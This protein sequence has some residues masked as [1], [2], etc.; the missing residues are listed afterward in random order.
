MKEG[1][2]QNESR[3]RTLDSNPKASRQA[4]IDVILQR[5]KE[6]NIQREED[7]EL[8]QGRFDTAQREELDEEELLQGKFDFI[9]TT[10]QEPVQREK[11]S[12]IAR[13]TVIQRVIIDDIEVNNSTNMPSW[14]QDGTDYHINLT[15]E[16]PHV[17]ASKARMPKIHFFFTG[18]GFEIEDKQP[19]KEE[20]GRV[21][22]VKGESIRTST[23]FSKLPPLV[24]TF[25]KK[26]WVAIFDGK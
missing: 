7:E 15:S 10:K 2:S 19:T 16:T 24:Q 23:V 17:T 12:H 18:S 11:K 20:R 6:R 1:V 22:K 13:L 5:Y 3:S 26:N 14:T 25:I 9:P 4:P 8:T 21:V